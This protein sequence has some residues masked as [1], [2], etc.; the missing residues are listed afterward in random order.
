[1]DTVNGLLKCVLL[2]LTVSFS[3]VFATYFEIM[4]NFFVNYLPLGFDNELSY[5]IKVRF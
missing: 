3:T 5:Q 4:F 2:I 1:M